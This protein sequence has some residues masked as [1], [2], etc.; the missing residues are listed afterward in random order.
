MKLAVT[1]VTSGVG[2]RLAEIAIARGDAVRGLVRDPSRPDAARLAALG[3]EI[4]RGD[5]DDRDALRRLVDGA[6]ATLHLAAHVGDV[7]TREQFFHVNVEGTANVVDAAAAAGVARFVQLSSSS[8]Y[9]RPDRGRV[10]EDWPRRRSGQPYDDTKSEAEEL[11]FD[12]GKQRGLVVVAIRPPIIYGPYD[13]N[14][15]PRAIDGIRAGRFLLIDGGR[16]PLNLV[17]VD[18]VVDVL[19]LAASAEASTVD[20][21]AF[22]VL[23]EVDARP[24]SVR[25]VAATIANEIGARPPTRS[26]PFGVA[27]LVG[28]VVETGF[29]LARARKPPP[30]TP[31]V[32][33]ILTRDVIYDAS[34][35]VRVLGWRPRMRTLE[36]IASFARAAR[37]SA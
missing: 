30:V 35:A 3:V 7:G 19:L 21:E 24:P 9:G 16:A 17:W 32:V 36:G 33:R 29:R 4:V 18:H 28:R 27:M 15:L 20:G 14:F 2:V 34:K 25:E 12:R 37:V 6:D 11:A 22:N 5:L 23:D 8:V 26:L 1:G 13:R 31:F 10:T